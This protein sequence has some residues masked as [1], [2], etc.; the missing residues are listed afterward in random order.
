VPPALAKHRTSRAKSSDGAVARRTLI[1]SYIQVAEDMKFR[2]EVAGQTGLRF[3]LPKT[4]PVKID[5]VVANSQETDA[6]SI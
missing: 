1:E 2:G 6:V 5:P 4:E 3:E